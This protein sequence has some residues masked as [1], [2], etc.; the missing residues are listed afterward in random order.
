MEQ[1]DFGSCGI[2]TTGDV[3]GQTRQIFVKVITDIVNLVLTQ[4]DGTDSFLTS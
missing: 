4:A 3:K 2:S 1:I